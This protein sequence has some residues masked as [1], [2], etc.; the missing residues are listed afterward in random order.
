ME[1]FNPSARFLI[2]NPESFEIL[3]S[4]S[5][6]SAPVGRFSGNTMGVPL[7]E[8]STSRLNSTILPIQGDDSLSHT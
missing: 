2:K 5:K 3:Y 4:S 1:D 8:I 6:G 7:Y